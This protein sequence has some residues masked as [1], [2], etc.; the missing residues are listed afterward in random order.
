[1]LDMISILLHVWRLTLWPNV[2][3]ILE[4]VLCVLENNVCSIAVGWNVL[5]VSVRYTGLMCS[6]SSVFFLMIF[7]LVELSIAE[8][9]VLKFLTIIV[10]LST[11]LYRYVNICFIYLGA[12]MFGA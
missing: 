2:C 9:G 5:Y 6:L 10:L 8:S 11:S 7:C 4:N 3:S 12:A 1:M